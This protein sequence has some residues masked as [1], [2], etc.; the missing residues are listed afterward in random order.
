MKQSILTSVKCSINWR[1]DM[2]TLNKEQKTLLSDE[3]LSMIK[4]VLTNLDHIVKARFDEIEGF[5]PTLGL[6][7]NALNSLCDIDMIRGMFISWNFF[8]GCAAYPVRG[9]K[10]YDYYLEEDKSQYDL[11]TEN[12]RL[13]ID[14]A[15]HCIQYIKSYF[16]IEG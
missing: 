6:C 13:R 8:S 3:Q 14:L 2:N 7:S 16:N 12:G 4:Q 1:E 5:E 11:S 9:G 15:K 10:V